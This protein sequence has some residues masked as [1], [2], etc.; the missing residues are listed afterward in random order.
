MD[1]NQ[2]EAE[3]TTFIMTYSYKIKNTYGIVKIINV[4]I[5]NTQMDMYVNFEVSNTSISGVIFT[6]VIKR[7]QIWLPNKE[8]MGYHENYLWIYAYC[9]D[10]H[11]CII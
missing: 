5:H 4:H 2:N 7:E 6:K 10:A 3:Q 1:M 8:Y 9:I 11:V